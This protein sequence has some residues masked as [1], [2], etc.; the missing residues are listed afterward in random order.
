[1]GGRGGGRRRTP[2]RRPT[3]APP[4]F[5]SLAIHRSAFC[6]LTT[7]PRKAGKATPSTQTTQPCPLSPRG[8]ERERVRG[9]T[10]DALPSCQRT[11]QPRH[12]QSPP[13]SF[14]FQFSIF[15]SKQ[16]SGAALATHPH[17]ASIAKSEQ[18][19]VILTGCEKMVARLFILHLGIYSRWFRPLLGHWEGRFAQVIDAKVI[20]ALH[21]SARSRFFHKL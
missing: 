7:C 15:N 1:M 10:R 9:R 19:P 17:P 13:H 8:G 16:G 2:R 14:N 5:S 11:R 6:V 12:S 4:L 21:R 20:L 3:T 18:T